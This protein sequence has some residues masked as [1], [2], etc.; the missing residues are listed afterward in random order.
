VDY[1]TLVAERI[2]QDSGIV[3]NASR[4][5]DHWASQ[6]FL[7]PDRC[8][9]WRRILR[10]AE[11]SGAGRDALLKLLRDDSEDAC[12]MKDF[13]PFAGALPRDERRRA[14]LS[15]SYDH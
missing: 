2:E 7:P 15:C 11:E 6:G 3:R 10:A 4:V 1:C 12:R 5:L 13:A 8:T 9:Q 14:F